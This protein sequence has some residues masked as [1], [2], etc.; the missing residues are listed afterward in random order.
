MRKD[1]VDDDLPQM[2]ESR[3]YAEYP[4]DEAQKEPTPLGEG[5]NNNTSTVPRAALLCLYFSIFIFQTKK[6]PASQPGV[7]Y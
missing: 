4:S 7:N 5:S 6:P 3:S 1:N 2:V